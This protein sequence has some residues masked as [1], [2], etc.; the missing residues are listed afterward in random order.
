MGS[1]DAD[2]RAPRFENS[3]AVLIGV[4][5][6][7]DPSLA[8]LESAVRN[9][10]GLA[11][12]LTDREIAGWPAERVITIPDPGNLATLG[13][14][15]RGLCKQATDTL[16]IYY[17]GHGLL[18]DDSRLHLSVATSRSDEVSFTAMP[19]D[20]IRNVTK[21]SPAASKLLI[22]DCCFSGRAIEDMSSEDNFVADRA[23]ID[24]TY[25]IT[26]TTRND[27]AKA[28]V[29]KAYTA[30]TGELI[31]LLSNGVP[32]GPKYLTANTLYTHLRIRLS[33]AGFPQPQS[34][35]VNSIDRLIL[36]RN[37]AAG[38]SADPPRVPQIVLSEVAAEDR[39]R[40]ADG[41][42]RRIERAIR[43][44]E[45][46]SSSRAAL[47]EWLEDSAER[48][49]NAAAELLADAMVQEDQDKAAAMRKYLADALKKT[50]LRQVLLK[51][52][53]LDRR[54]EVRVASAHCLAAVANDPAVWREL[55]PG[56]KY[57]DRAIRAAVVDSLAEVVRVP[58]PQAA[59]LNRLTAD[60]EI[61]V[62]AAAARVLVGALE[63]DVV[64]E[65]LTGIL[66]NEQPEVEA[67]AAT[68][69][70]TAMTSPGVEW[71]L[72]HNLS[73]ETAAHPALRQPLL[74]RLNHNDPEIRKLAA[75]ELE[76]AA[77]HPEVSAALVDR[78]TSDESKD[79]RA[80]AATSL[81]RG[82]GEP[83][84]WPWLLQ[85]LTDA[86]K[87]VRWRAAIS[88][89]KAVDIPEVRDAL[90]V[91]LATDDDSLVRSAAAS[92]LDGAS[93]DPAVLAALVA[94]LARDQDRV[95]DAA[96]GS[97]QSEL[98]HQEVLREYLAWLAR[99][100]GYTARRGLDGLINAVTER[101]V[102][103]AV[104]AAVRSN[105]KLRQGL[106]D[107]LKWSTNT[108]IQVAL[109]EALEPVARQWKVRRILKNVGTDR[110]PKVAAAV[111]KAL[112]R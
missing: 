61:E 49:R 79:V 66:G 80:Q 46:D 58:E 103:D 41:V 18:S 33:T 83:S 35:G 93:D 2:L 23:T 15:L 104:R 96:A 3:Y 4:G 72:R 84:V 43:R 60:E 13:P 110:D 9:L 62:R 54:V 95:Q 73:R 67:A 99:R 26:S 94:A 107:K 56:L 31:D 75:D 34:R 108:E 30:F 5:T 6:Y 51:R 101:T 22:L 89:S 78:I 98:M 28:P 59:L 90:V 38:S 45:T 29:G 63:D 92:A 40:A 12:T 77:E 1:E 97:L 8:D 55:L 32:G 74:V 82:A 24:G 53:A 81:A 85:A 47:L 7:E 112:G 57:N 88:L 42:I 105:A 100:E 65:A 21:S 25:T 64:R 111:A 37:V 52:L 36:A 19:Y 70:A 14:E 27:A 91:G 50:P 106:L 10:A 102:R 87:S 86:D 109:I 20:W 16:L 48:T 69:L 11:A 17:C 76:V 68:S 71:E 39:P 44:V